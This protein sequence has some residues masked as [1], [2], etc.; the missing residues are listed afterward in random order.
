METRRFGILALL[1]WLCSAPTWAA[2]SLNR[3]EPAFWWVG[4]KNPELQ[5]LLQGKNIGQAQISLAPYPG[6]SL[7]RVAKVKNP[8][9]TF[10]YVEIGPE[11]KAGDLKF[12]FAG[13]AK[14][15]L[16]Y[17]LKARDS[18][19]KAQGYT[20]ADVVYLIMPDRF[21]NGNPKNDSV[22]GMLEA[23]RRKQDFGRHGGD[24]EGITNQLG[25]FNKLGVTA[26][27]LNPVQENDMAASSYHGYA[28]TDYYAADRR[29]GGNEAYLKFIQQAHGAGLKV[30]MDMVMNHM[31]TNHYWLKDLPDSSFI[32]FWPKYTPSNFRAT[33]Q[34]DPYRSQY[35]QDRMSKGWFDKTMADINGA[36]PLVADYLIQN[37]IWWVEHGCIDDIRMDTYPYPDKQFMN[38]WAT[39]LTAE[40]PKLN[41]V[42]E[43]WVDDIPLAAYY[44][45]N[46][47]NFNGFNSTEPTVMDFPLR[48][49]IVNGLNDEKPDYSNGLVKIYNTLA[50]D[51]VYE[52]PERNMTF[53]NNHDMSR[54]ATSLKGSVA[55]TKMALTLLL[56]LRGV[57]HLYYGEE[58]FMTGD[59]KH[60][61][62]VR[63][64]FAGGWAGDTVNFFTG[65]NVP[66][67]RQ[68]VFN[69]YQKLLQWRK[70]ATAIH[71]GRMTQFV[72]DSN[73]YVYFRHLPAKQVMVVVNGNNT[74]KTLDL[75]RFAE[76]LGTAKKGMDIVSGMGVDF[77]QRT[78][79]L[80][81]MTSYIIEVE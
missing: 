14:G 39:R 32:N 70:T 76:R 68:E 64:D 23:A 26:L 55:K 51:F 40:Y 79:R 42:G 66:A 22:K 72:P 7:K 29:F 21:A 49:A 3:V 77:T 11:A 73:V 6:V 60:H 48:N 12:T 18:K 63:K 30:V 74:R 61:P 43:V 34:V 20:P 65:K 75:Q 59:G 62:D 17:T 81:P 19:V 2:F 52:T 8:N 58:W 36:N 47:K 53:C 69:Y 57:P 37:C 24:I 13:A 50:Q 38:Q 4:M 46:N 1:M 44:A 16:A 25:Y 5:I 35:D 41:L 71:N 78:L 31:G 67:Q 45:K 9:Y 10:V 80:E 56:T 15:N 27:W 33:A 54:T 28:I